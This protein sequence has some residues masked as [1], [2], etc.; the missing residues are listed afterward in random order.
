MWYE[1][2]TSDQLGS[3]LCDL[4]IQPRLHRAVKKWVDNVSVK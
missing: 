2:T 4:Q 3:L 1:L